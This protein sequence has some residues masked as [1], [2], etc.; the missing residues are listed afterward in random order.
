MQQTSLLSAMYISQRTYVLPGLPGRGAKP[1]CRIPTVPTASSMAPYP[2]TE[3]R[4]KEEEHLSGLLPCRPLPARLLKGS[5]Q[6]FV[7]R[8]LL[9]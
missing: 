6:Q 5:H 1:T 7:K 9:L 3:G 4:Q 2:M 8:E